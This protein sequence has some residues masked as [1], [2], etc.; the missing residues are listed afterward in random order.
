MPF[1]ADPLGMTFGRRVSLAFGAMF[2]LMVAAAWRA[3]SGLSAVSEV[4]R[5]GLQRDAVLAD[6]A[7]HARTDALTLRR[8]EKDQFLNLGDAANMKDY[9]EKWETARRALVDRLAK[10][11][12]MVFLPA[13]RQQVRAMTEG[14]SAY[15]AGLTAVI[16]QLTA[17]STPQDANRLLGPYKDAIRS[18]EQAAQGLADGAGRRAAENAP[19][20]EKLTSDT[21]TQLALALLFALL[22]A[23]IVAY[24]LHRS[25][26]RPLARM[27]ETADK[28]ARGDVGEAAHP[29]VT[30]SGDEA[31]HLETAFVRSTSILRDMVRELDALISASRDGELSRRAD[32]SRFP[33]AYGKLLAGANELLDQLASPL[34]GVAEGTQTLLRAAD[35]VQGVSGRMTDRAQHTSTQA[36]EVSAAT[37]QVSRSAQSVS[38]AVEQLTAAIQ[39]ISANANEAAGTASAAR[40]CA[41]EATSALAALAGRSSSIGVVVRTIGSIARQ[42]NLLALNATIEA[43]RAGAAGKG[44]AVVAGEVKELAKSA[45]SAS[46]SISASIE[47]MI[48]EIEKAARAVASLEETMRQ[49]D[50]HTTSIAGAVE[51]QL[52]ATGHIR[53][54]ID[55]ATHGPV[56][57]AHSVAQVALAA[58]ATSEDAGEAAA[59]AADLHRLADRLGGLVGRYRFQ[60]DASPLTM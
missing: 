36:T 5:R 2:I 14:L 60:Q 45:S 23:P 35:R 37:E 55:D 19:A 28:L 17:R 54:S 44:F 56:A 46:E 16:G 8:F 31:S 50:Q 3:H 39:H 53:R 58:A 42:T 26:T 9:A 59:S 11:D 21:S 27:L 10:L 51:E 41:G 25:V 18:L 13:E 38:T 47:Q 49:V 6:A 20:I 7:M 12:A 29:V 1:P 22:G 30:G 32:P 57:I 34:R 52:A 4:A 40:R 15:T 24:L 33:G 43:A 48:A